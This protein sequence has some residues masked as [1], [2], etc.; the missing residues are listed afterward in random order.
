MKRIVLLMLSAVLIL[1]AC[2]APEGI[3]VSGVWARMGDTGA[4]SAVYFVIQNHNAEADNLV[5]ASSNI[6]DATE[7]HESKMEG[8]V[9]MMNHL[10][11]VTLEP[12]AKVEFMPGGLHIMLIGLKQDL[13]PGDE[14][15]VILH[16]ENSPDLLVKAAVQDA[17]SM[18]GMK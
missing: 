14:V 17:D 8:D 13:N 15:E 1:S 10:E 12:S 3:E 16:F 6:A 2:G 11:S 7:V 9:M 4:N 18:P 5:G